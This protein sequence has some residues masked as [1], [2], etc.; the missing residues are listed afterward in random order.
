MTFNGTVSSLFGLVYRV[1]M[2]WPSRV[3]ELGLLPVPLLYG[4]KQYS[5]NT[6]IGEFRPL[7]RS[8]EQPFFFT[9]FLFPRS[10]Y[11][12]FPTWGL[13]LLALYLRVRA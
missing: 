13:L 7:C 3:F 12:S 8:Q 5:L 11:T 6:Q 2:I 10:S 4:T 1:L 9:F